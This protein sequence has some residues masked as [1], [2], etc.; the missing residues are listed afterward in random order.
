MVKNNISSSTEDSI[1]NNQQNF[2]QQFFYP[3][4]IAGLILLW[5]TIFVVT[6]MMC[7]A[8]KRK[9]VRVAR[10]EEQRRRGNTLHTDEGLN[11]MLAA[12]RMET[13]RRRIN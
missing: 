11:S 9:R 4:R 13:L 5:L 1:N 10:E 12:G 7:V 2:P 6:F 3:I 8:R